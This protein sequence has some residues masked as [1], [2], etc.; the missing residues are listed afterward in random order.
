MENKKKLIAPSVLSADLNCL[1]K[2]VLAVEKAGADWIHLD[3]MDGHFVS[4]ITFGAGAARHIH[5]ITS[6]PIDAHLMVKNPGDHVEPF[7]QAGVRALSVHYEAFSNGGELKQVLKKIQSL[8]VLSG[9]ALKPATPAESVFPFLPELD[10]VLVMTVEP[11]FSG[12][13]FLPHQVKKI[14]KIQNELKKIKKEVKIQVDGGIN[15]QTAKQA[16][17]A[18]IFVAGHFIFKSRDYKR[19]VEELKNAVTN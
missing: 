3:V 16:G 6:L 7:A 1:G 13:V 9:L 17:S 11:G 18:D 14:Q 12:Q 15:S 5:S 2:E 10:F 19:A 4:P 8:N